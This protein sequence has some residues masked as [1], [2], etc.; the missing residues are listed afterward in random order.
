MLSRVYIQTKASK[1]GGKCTS[2]IRTEKKEGK[3]VPEVHATNF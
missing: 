1:N 2:Y 3:V